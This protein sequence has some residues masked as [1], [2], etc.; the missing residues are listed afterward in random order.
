MDGEAEVSVGEDAAGESSPWPQP[1]AAMIAIE[2]MIEAL[3][4]LRRVRGT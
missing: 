4:A 2:R 3:L 1:V